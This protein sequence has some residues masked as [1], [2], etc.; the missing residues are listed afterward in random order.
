MLVGVTGILAGVGSDW[1]HLAVGGITLQIIIPASD[2]GSLGS[3]GSQVNL[4]TYLRFLNDQPVLYGFTSKAALDLFLLT[5]GVTG[6]GPRM[7]LSLLSDLG[8]AGL[9]KAIAEEDAA[10]LG[11]VSG[12]G[13]RTASRIILELKGKVE[14]EPDKLAA[15]PIGGD[16]EVIAALTALGYSS[17]EARRAVASLPRSPEL[18]VEDYIRQALLHIGSA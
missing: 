3:T 6:V 2:I 13:R 17:A 7:S 10:T 5:T 11:S 18:T 12:V 4:F 1:V 15:A 14:L 16:S 8:A 9:R